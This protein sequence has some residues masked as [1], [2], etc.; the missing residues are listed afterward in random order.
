M[1]PVKPLI[2]VALVFSP[3]FSLAEEAQDYRLPEISVLGVTPKASAFDYLPTVSQVS[4]VKLD[5]KRQS[6]I[7]ETL[8]KEAGVSSSFFGPNASRPVIRGLDGDRV[9]MLENGIGVL[10]AS[11]A[12]PDHAIAIDP[13]LVESF[14]ILRGPSALLYGSSAVGGVVNVRTNRISEKLIDENQI[15][16]NT[17]YSSV[18]LGKNLGGVAR[19]KLGNYVLHFDGSVRSSEDYKV[20]G[21]AK[22]DPTVGDVENKVLNSANRASQAAAGLSYHFDR[23]YIGTA[24]SGYLSEYGTTKSEEGN[25]V[26]I[27][28]DR[29]RADLAGEVK[30][31]GFLDS[32]RFKTAYSKYEHKEIAGSE[33]GT[34]FRNRG[35]ETRVDA[36]KGDLLVGAQQQYFKFSA[37]GVEAFLPTTSNASYAVFGYQEW[38]FGRVKPAFGLRLDSANVTSEASDQFGVGQSKSFFAPSSSLGFQYLL[39]QPATGEHEW[40]LGLNGT[41]TERAP[42]YQELFANGEHVATGI[43]ERG[44]TGFKTEKNTG[45]ELSVK[46]KGSEHE[47]RLAGF[48]QGFSNYIALNPTGTFEDGEDGLPGTEDDIPVYD[49][50]SVKAQLF[51]AELEYLY[52]IP[53]AFLNGNW[54][55]EFKWDWVRGLDRTNNGNLA[56][57]TP[58]RGT[59]G[60][61]YRHAAFSAELEFQRVEGQSSLSAN[62]TPTSGYN[63]VNLGGE[64]P[65]KTGL[66]QLKAIWRVSNVFDVEARNH[67]S[68]LKDE[69]PLPGRNLI[70]GLQAQI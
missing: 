33:V 40:T 5:R 55:T 64:V 25:D 15:S 41:Y 57:M 53:T 50:Q 21:F 11:G 47:G 24:F 65:I 7:G 36:K 32:V 48:Y 60:V 61:N 49:Y 37:N 30:Q 31:V 45:V 52:K 20:P 9:R 56:R 62:E 12:S 3:V 19:Y 1:K 46:V 43:V 14:E 38:S 34:V 13:M 27:N 35:I 42:N 29:A 28:M 68:F 4:G 58:M 8:S 23:G 69:V 18:D 2:A 39:N 51:G 54:E 66:G 67:V 26:K 17:R 59:L 10:D 70:I 44:N 16:F 63:R 22:K 6:T